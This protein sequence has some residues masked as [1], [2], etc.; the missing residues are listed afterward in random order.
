[1]DFDGRRFNDDGTIDVSGHT[2]GFVTGK[3]YQQSFLGRTPDEGGG[4]GYTFS[5]KD[6]MS[7]LII[8]QTESMGALSFS[9][10]EAIWW[11]GIKKQT[12][13]NIAGDIYSEGEIGEM[14]RSTMSSNDEPSFF[15]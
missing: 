4:G 7:M 12:T 11:T 8:L 1:M 14:H 6:A 5:G 2:P 9:N 10:G 15:W 13:Y 3:Q